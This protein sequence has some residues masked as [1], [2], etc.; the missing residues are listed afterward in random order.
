MILDY[1]GASRHLSQRWM[2]RQKGLLYSFTTTAR[3]KASASTSRH[4][5][6]VCNCVGALCARVR[7]SVCV[8]VCVCVYIAVK[9]AEL[10]CRKRVSCLFTT[11]LSLLLAY[12]LLCWKTG[13]ICEACQKRAGHRNRSLLSLLSLLYL[14][15][16]LQSLVICLQSLLMSLCRVWAKRENIRLNMSL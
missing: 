9:L 16:S 2:A 4:A 8:C 13:P 7:L 3:G 6:N 12:E 1:R 11:S 15:V 10:A 14:F 5:L